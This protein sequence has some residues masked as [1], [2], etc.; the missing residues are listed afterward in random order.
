MNVKDTIG[1]RIRQRLYKIEA[2]IGPFVKKIIPNFMAAHYA[3]IISCCIFGS[4][5]IYP[6]KN[7]AYIDCLLFATGAST[8]AGLNSID[9]NELTLHQQIMLYVLA[10]IS[11]P[12]Y[13][14]SAVVFLRLWWFEKTFDGIK[15]R[16]KE[17]FRMRRSATLAAFR[18]QT[19]EENFPRT[20]TMHTTNG[21]DPNTY[22]DVVHLSEPS[23]SEEETDH[24]QGHVY[25]TPD[26]TIP[27]KTEDK[28]IRFANLPKPP[29][30]RDKEIE[31]RD[32]YMSISMM[33]HNK[34]Q[35]NNNDE[36]GPALV[37]RGPAEREERPLPGH[38]HRYRSHLKQRRHIKHYKKRL[39]EKLA[40]QKLTQDSVSESEPEET[41]LPVATI[42]STPPAEKLSTRRPAGSLSIQFE[43]PKKPVRRESTT[44]KLSKLSNIAAL[45]KHSG[46]SSSEDEDSDLSAEFDSNGELSSDGGEGVASDNDAEE[47]EVEGFRNTSPTYL[48][49]I[50]TV[51]RNSTFVTLTDQQK[52]ELGGV[53]YRSIKL[54][55]WILIMYFVGFSVLAT[56]MFV[57]FIVLRKHYAEV[58]RACGVSPTWWGFFTSMSCFTDLGFTLT[59]NS[60]ISFR[61]NGYIMIISSFFIVVGNTGFPIFLRF[62]IWCLHKA[63]APLTLRHESSRF[64]LDHPRRCFTLL[65]PSGPTWWLFFVLVL[66]NVIDWLLFIILDFHSEVLKDTRPGYRVLDGLFQAFSTRTAGFAITDLS[67][68]NPGIQVSYLVMMYISVLPLAIS[69]RQTNV[70]E[71]QSLGIYVDHQAENSDDSTAENSRVS[72]IGTHL[73]RQLSFDLWFLFLGLFIICINESARLKSGDTHFSIFSVLFEITSAYGTVGLSLGYPNFNTSFCGQFKTLSKLVIIA[74]MIRGRH[75]GLPYSIDRAIML[76]TDKTNLRDDIQTQQELRRT[77]TLQNAYSQAS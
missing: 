1:F 18:T 14:H 74:M 7:I 34:Q 23:D 26:L 13:I 68:L 72:F 41:P 35:Q 64:L 11:N 37:I 30:R 25:S 33:Q 15:Q 58:V 5:I 59:P 20:N 22:N 45:P 67:S 29:R 54:L 53:E 69:I 66:L 43:D 38:K 77:H 60:M 48:S 57:P 3:Y 10:M 75:R 17:N 32:L 8:Q 71:E 62:I 55:G 65:F 6:T 28:D 76:P 47:S 2:T 63:S 36:S 9:V 46:P 16:S 12:I 24:N 42:V 70:Y 4:I 39:R 49:W 51:G 61:E 50:P 56:I 19:M 52:E 40:Q 27:A 73:R 31:P 21:F 44:P